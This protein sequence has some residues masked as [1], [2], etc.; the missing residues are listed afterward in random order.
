MISRLGSDAD[1]ISFL[2]V[3]VDPNRDS[4]QVLGDYVRNF[5]PQIAGLR[6]TP[7]QLTAL[8][9]RY[10]LVYSVT[11]GGAGQPYEVSHSSA[12]Y[13]FDGAGAARLLLPSLSEA[14]N[15]DGTMADL[16]RLIAERATV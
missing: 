15:I 8:A 11:P 3:T 1:R 9:R 12:I 14:S 2:F 16:K 5:A 13:V 6:G 10:R 4:L 7:D